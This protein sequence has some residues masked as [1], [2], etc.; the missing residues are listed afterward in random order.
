MSFNPLTG[1]DSTPAPAPQ[2]SEAKP[3]SVFPNQVS[4]KVDQAFNSEE[5]QQF[6]EL[7]NKASNTKFATGDRDTDIRNYLRFKA[8]ISGLL[9]ML[10]EEDGR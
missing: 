5:A 8:N 4:E 9:T 7:A 3:Q 6:Q 2:Q 1:A 10:G